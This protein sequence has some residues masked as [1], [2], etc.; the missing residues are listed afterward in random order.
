MTINIKHVEI[1]SYKYFAMVKITYMLLISLKKYSG[2]FWQ[3]SSSRIHQSQS[4]A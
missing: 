1:T 4:T 2:Q 3:A